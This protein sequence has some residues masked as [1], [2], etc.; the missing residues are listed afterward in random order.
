MYKDRISRYY[1]QSLGGMAWL[2][3]HPA[4][5]GLPDRFPVWVHDWVVGF[6]PGWGA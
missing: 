6:I 2:G 3:H 1:E 5:I 4:T